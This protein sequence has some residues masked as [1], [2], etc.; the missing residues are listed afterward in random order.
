[1]PPDQS[2]TLRPATGDDLPALADL[3]FRV[4]EAAFPAMP[5][6]LH[7]MPEV[8]KW[9]T[10]W[11]LDRFEVWLAEAADG[12]VGYAR[13]DQEWLDD[14]YVD[15]EAQGGGIGTALLDL[16]KA[17]RP[18]GFCLWV[19]E[20]NIPARAFYAARG[21]VELERTDGSGNEEKEPDLRMAWPGRDPVRFY[22][23]LI[24]EVDAGLG[25]LLNRRAAVTRAIQ[26]H[27]GGPSRD[28]DR[29]REIA[30]ALAVRAP[31]LGEERLLRIVH[32]VIAESLDAA[33]TPDAA[34]TLD[35]AT[36]PDAATSVE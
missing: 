4:R 20:S 12:P 34:T 2:L 9:V 1:M 3:H 18:N 26:P 22:R 23:R 5:R 33:T 24:D 7:P 10:G 21:L 14:L 32:Q 29:E 25:E 27:K 19:F 13:L 15:P 17:Q 31:T 30:R 28:P 36:T 11:N 6:S 8:Q 35:A 16:V